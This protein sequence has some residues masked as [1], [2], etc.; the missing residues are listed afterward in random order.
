MGGYKVSLAKHAGR[1]PPPS[2]QWM[3]PWGLEEGFAARELLNLMLLA[4]LEPPSHQYLTGM[5]RGPPSCPAAWVSAQRPPPHGTGDP[6]G[7]HVPGEPHP[8]THQSFPA[9]AP[10]FTKETQTRAGCK[11][12]VLQQVPMGPTPCWGRSQ[13]SPV[14]LPA[15]RRWVHCWGTFLLCCSLNKHIPY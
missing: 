10:I 1:N 3:M 11:P 2:P 8:G 6:P 5:M 13:C 15:V 14:Q 12:G 9:L 7:A 4:R